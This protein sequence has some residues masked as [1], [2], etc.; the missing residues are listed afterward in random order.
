MT[1][2]LKGADFQ[3]TGPTERFAGTFSKDGASLSGTWERS[4]DGRTWQPWMDI[5]LQKRQVP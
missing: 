3:I 2:D 5:T 1:G 4:E